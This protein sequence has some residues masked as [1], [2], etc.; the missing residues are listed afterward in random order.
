VG[1]RSISAYD[2]RERVASYDADMDVM[3]PNRSKM[4]RVALEVL[5]FPRTSPLLALDLG[6]GTGYFSGEFLNHFPSSRVL[7]VDGAKAMVDV[8]RARLGP[9]A[10]R[11]DFRVGDFRN[12]TTLVADVHGLGVVFSSYALHHLDRLAKEA[13]IRQAVSLLRSGGWF[14]NADLIIADS[15]AME[16]RIQEIRV[17]GIVARAGGAD[18]RFRDAA[19]TRQFL[20]ELEAR[21][22]DQPLTLLDDL[23]ILRS[24]GLRNPSV[25]WLEYREVVYGSQK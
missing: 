19:A 7:A 22:G 21:E 3:H 24:V 9:L 8:A 25:F 1:E 2:L 13:V 14:L 4:V 16:T 20:D 23:A 11:V 15:P 18:E 17:A 12:L 5:P 10:S 6:I